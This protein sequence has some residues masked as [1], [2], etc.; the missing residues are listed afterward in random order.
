MGMNSGGQKTLRTSEITLKILEKLKEND[1]LTLSEV[2]EEL[3]IAKST[4]HRHLNT[5]LEYEYIV[6]ENDRYHIGLRF[7]SM[8]VHA[9]RNRTIYKTIKSKVRQ[10]AEET[11][12]LAHYTVVEHDHVVFLQQERGNRAVKM[13]FDLDRRGPL[14]ASSAGKAILAEKSPDEIDQ[15]IQ[16]NEL[17]VR[18]DHTISDPD[19]LRSEL[20]QIQ[21]RGYSISREEFMEELNAV[22]V[23]IKDPEEGTLGVIS[24][25]GPASR[26]QGERLEETVPEILLGTAHEIELN[27]KYSQ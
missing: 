9:R 20:E 6:R 13:N 5:L 21:E 11:G 2:A 8:G 12:E 10:L 15:Y 26:L 1:G 3:S 14:H 18:T 4:A 7:F 22:A 19:Q 16:D 17:S 24:I 27:L 25:L 23:P